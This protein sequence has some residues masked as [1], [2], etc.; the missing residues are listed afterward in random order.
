[1]FV[2]GQKFDVAYP[3]EAAQWCNDNG[4]IIASVD[5]GFEI[6]K[7]PTSTANQLYAALRIA[8][9][10]RL[11]NTDKM[12]LADYPIATDNLTLV[13]EYRTALRDLPDQNGAPWDG[14]GESTPWPDTPD[15][16]QTEQPCA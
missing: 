3:P 10:M 12:L 13:R 6:Q 1:M 2:I 9:D 5:G 11:A 15:F 7:V 8:R 14:G 4:A 16:M